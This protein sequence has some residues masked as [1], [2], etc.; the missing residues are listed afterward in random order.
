MTIK[1]PWMEGRLYFGDRAADSLMVMTGGSRGKGA[2]SVVCDPPNSEAHAEMIWKWAS[3]GTQSTP[4]MGTMSCGQAENATI[5][6][7]SARSVT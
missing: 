3:V 6:S 2:V 5:Q 1:R 7:I 4:L